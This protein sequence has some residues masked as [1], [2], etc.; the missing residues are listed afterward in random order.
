MVRGPRLPSG[1]RDCELAP[2]L[3]HHAAI[4][5]GLHRHCNR[6]SHPKSPG[7]DRKPLCSPS[8]VWRVSNRQSSGTDYA[9]L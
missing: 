3:R 2:I 7:I 9:L 4:S 6:P 5:A 8:L 1:A